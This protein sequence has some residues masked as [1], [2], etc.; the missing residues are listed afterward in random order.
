MLYYLPILLELSAQIIGLPIL[1]F[2][3]II[4]P[5]IY[6]IYLININRFESEKILINE[7]LQLFILSILA[8]QRARTVL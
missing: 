2:F 1:L 8:P 5:F 4:C 7:N 3:I 6:V